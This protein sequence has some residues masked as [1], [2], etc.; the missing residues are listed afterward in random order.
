[1]S[2]TRR[3]MLL[4]SGALLV[5]NAAVVSALVQGWFGSK[6]R[7]KMFA[8]VY[9]RETKEIRRLIDTAEDPDDSHLLYA[10]LVLAPDEVMEAFQVRD[11]PRRLPRY[12]A[13]HIGRGVIL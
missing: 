10:R 5:S 4:G 2:A 13:P 1:M 12:L 3:N 7:S 9:E 6:D 8:I 11:F